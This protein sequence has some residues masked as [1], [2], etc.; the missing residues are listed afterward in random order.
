MSEQYSM[1]QMDILTPEQ[2]KIFEITEAIHEIDSQLR[3][4]EMALNIINPDSGD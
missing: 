3:E 4:I 2:M 1:V